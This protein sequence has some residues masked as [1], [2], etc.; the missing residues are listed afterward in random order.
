MIGV[1]T[2]VE[3]DDYQWEPDDRRRWLRE[4][5]DWI[6][7]DVLQ[8]HP[9]ER[10]AIVFALEVAG[11]YL[12]TNGDD[13]DLFIRLALTPQQI[14][15]NKFIAYD[16][17]T[18]SFIRG[19]WSTMTDIRARDARQ[20]AID[21]RH[22]YKHGWIEVEG[23]GLVRRDDAFPDVVFPRFPVDQGLND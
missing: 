16:R 3:L 10:A 11:F 19:D 6:V 20:A 1:D 14:A 22:G 21:D 12:D 13:P 18:L 5:L 8:V 15:A 4:P 17:E 23:H 2:L 7:D 9:V